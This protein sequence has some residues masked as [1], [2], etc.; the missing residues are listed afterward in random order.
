V[1]W[2]L[3]LCEIEPARLELVSSL[4][5]RPREVSA[6]VLIDRGAIHLWLRHRA[7]HKFKQQAHD[8]LIAQLGEDRDKVR[9]RTVVAVFHA[10]PRKM[11]EL[12]GSA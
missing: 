7:A 4:N 8:V 2:W 6:L 12:G 9:F 10:V 1:G 11:A 3:S 5:P